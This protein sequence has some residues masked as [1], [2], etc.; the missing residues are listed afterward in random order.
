MGMTAQL[1]P[2]TK[3]EARRRYDH[4]LH[5]AVGNE[6]YHTVGLGYA[7]T[8]DD[9]GGIT[10]DEMA[11][12]SVD[13]RRPSCVFW[14]R[15]ITAEHD[16][17][18][19]APARGEMTPVRAEE[20]S[21]GQQVWPTP[22][23]HE[24]SRTLTEVSIL[25]AELAADEIRAAGGQPHERIEGVHVLDGPPE[26]IFQVVRWRFRNG[27]AR[28][29]WHGTTV[30]AQLTEPFAEDHDTAGYA[31]ADAVGCPH[32]DDHVGRVSSHVD[33]RAGLTKPHAS[34]WVCHRF[35]CRARAIEV[36]RRMT[37]R[38][39]QFVAFV[40]SGRDGSDGEPAAS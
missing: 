19:S 35:G 1:V 20:A 22:P 40:S 38:P 27:S 23:G 18:A 24:A 5:V 12:R 3:R 11:A 7:F 36:V 10:F 17:N 37:G 29:F 31:Y 25:E 34:G 28:Y 6:L 9:M 15:P 16:D 26:A 30:V 8:R 33:L 39:G 13:S 21:P 4:G 14:F 2:C 32:R